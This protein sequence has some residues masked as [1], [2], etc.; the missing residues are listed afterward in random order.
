M[1]NLML[2]ASCCGVGCCIGA[3]LS[4]IRCAVLHRLCCAVLP[5]RMLRSGPQLP[6]HCS[7]MV[8]RAVMA[9]TTRQAVKMMQF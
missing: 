1:P 4:C 8:P 6:H 2:F 7:T 3:A 9:A 5:S